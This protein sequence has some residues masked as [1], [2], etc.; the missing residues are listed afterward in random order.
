MATK[1]IDI[2]DAKNQLSELLML[3]KKGTD[4]ILA[5]DD[6]PLARLVPVG[7]KSSRPRIAGLHEGA[8]LI[9]EDF[10]DPLPDSFWLGK[11]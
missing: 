1:T 7:D 11:E 4:I 6:I 10:D 5:Q 8:F 3:A 2:N 9:S